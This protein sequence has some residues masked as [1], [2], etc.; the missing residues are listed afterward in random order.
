MHYV[1][2]GGSRSGRWIRIIVTRCEGITRETR[3]SCKNDLSSSTRASYPRRASIF[4]FGALA[5]VTSSCSSRLRDIP[6]RRQ[7]Q[8]KREKRRGGTGKN[9]KNEKENGRVVQICLVVDWA[10]PQSIARRAG[11][12]KSSTITSARPGKSRRY[13]GDRLAAAARMR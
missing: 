4:I 7:R 1:R 6:H 8:Q 13:A 3:G 12:A 11:S 10:I 2:S 5:R 9:G